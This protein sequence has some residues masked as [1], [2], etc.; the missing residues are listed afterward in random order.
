V[1]SYSPRKVAQRGFQMNTSKTQG[2]PK[3]SLHD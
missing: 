3:S 1:P 2:N